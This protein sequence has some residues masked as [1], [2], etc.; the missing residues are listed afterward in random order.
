MQFSFSG[1]L[2]L[3]STF[4]L[5]IVI[6]VGLVPQLMIVLR[7][8]DE[9]QVS[10]LCPLRRLSYS[11]ELL[12]PGYAKLIPDFVMLGTCLLAS[13]FSNVDSHYLLCKPGL[14]TIASGTQRHCRRCRGLDCGMEEKESM[15]A[16]SHSCFQA[17]D[18]S[19]LLLLAG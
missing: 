10:L 13:S 14:F 4:G 15:T 19:S 16:F 3:W 18:S 7:G 12:F 2:A 8:L 6:F 5:G 9:L 1:A 17:H 11:S